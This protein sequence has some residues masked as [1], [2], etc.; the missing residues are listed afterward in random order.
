MPEKNTI[1]FFASNGAIIDTIQV[2]TAKYLQDYVWHKGEIFARSHTAPNMPP[3]T[4]IGYAWY[5]QVG[6]K[7]VIKQ[8]NPNIPTI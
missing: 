3:H 4:D 2:K 5:V 1:H 7:T 8:L 6:M